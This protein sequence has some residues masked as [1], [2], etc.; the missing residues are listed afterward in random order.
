MTASD[1]TP[2]IYMAKLNKLHLLKEIFTEIQVTPE[3]KR[4]AIDKGKE[5][6][7]ID[8]YI[9]EEALKEGW[10]VESS[11]TEESM[12]RCKALALIAGIDI[13]EA[14]TIFIARQKNQKIVLID[15]SNAR[16]AARQ[17]GLTPRGTIYVVLSAAKRKILTKT[18]AKQIL[19]ML[20]EK[21]FYVSAKIYRDALK[22]IEE[23]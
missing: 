1:A 13:G 22:A 14:Q 20:I 6:G 15:Q 5:K 10:I 19:E 8:T 7:Y 11:L 9:I 18:E 4:E 17:L 23:L 3:V 16:E 21:N 12:E 2:L